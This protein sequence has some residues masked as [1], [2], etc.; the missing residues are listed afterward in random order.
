MHDNQTL[1]E[2]SSSTDMD[3]DELDEDFPEYR[4][5]TEHRWMRLFDDIVMYEIGPYFFGS[6]N[7]FEINNMERLISCAFQLVMEKRWETIE[8]LQR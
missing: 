6:G 8:K 1:Q 4:R 5:E 3:M 2:S 7:H